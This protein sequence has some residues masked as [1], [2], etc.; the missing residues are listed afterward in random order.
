MRVDFLTDLESAVCAALVRFRAKRGA[1]L[2]PLDCL[3]FDL[4][5]WSGYINLSIRAE[6]D[7]FPREEDG[8]HLI[9]DWEHAHFAVSI[10]EPNS[11]RGWPEARS[12]GAEMLALFEQ[13][14]QT[15][16]ELSVEDRASMFYGACAALGSM[17]GLWGALDRFERA[18]D[19]KIVVANVDHPDQAIVIG[20]DAVAERPSS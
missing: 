13:L 7:E 17:P 11:S 2:R 14:G 16:P 15:N 8:R 19:F 10:E 20:E 12:L 5:P 6:D 18:P 4:H 9:S 3:A 1:R